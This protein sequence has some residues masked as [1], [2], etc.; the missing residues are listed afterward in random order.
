MPIIT[1]PKI[2][3]RWNLFYGK[4]TV[5]SFQ[6]FNKSGISDIIRINY[7]KT[8]EDL[9]ISSLKKK[10]FILEKLAIPGAYK[11]QKH[12][13]SL[14][15]TH[16][17]LL[18]YYSIQGL[19]SQ[20]VSHVVHPQS[21]D[22]ILDMSAAPGGKTAHLSSLMQNKGLI[23]A[24][25]SSKNRM[26]ALRSNLARLGIKN[27]LAFHG[28]A[29]ELTPKFGLFDKILL[30]APCSGSGSIC[31]R[32]S[33]EWLKDES[34]IE[35]LAKKQEDLLMTGIKQLKIGGEL[36]YSTC[37][38]EPEEGE[39]QIISLIENLGEKISIME[40]DKFKSVFEPVVL[41]N[42]NANKSIFETNQDKWLRITPNT[43][44][45]GFFICKVKKEKEL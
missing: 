33:K 34:D 24:V 28:D 7:L 12:R 6:Y 14:G 21:S 25:D 45:E 10:G 39:K 26:T 9:L 17:F 30:D 15:A 4:P 38:L 43:D 35:R 31:K 36:T 40:I 1:D 13:I 44:Y 42:S 2:V 23:I 27:V 22:R 20:Y 3:S 41:H 8:S 32:P 16:E 5:N 18:G 11:I 37:S 29:I 19:A